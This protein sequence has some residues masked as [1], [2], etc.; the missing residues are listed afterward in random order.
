MTQ[1]KTHPVRSDTIILWGDDENRED[2]LIKGR[3]CEGSLIGFDKRQIWTVYPYKRYSS[4]TEYWGACERK[5][6][7]IRLGP[8]DFKKIFGEDIV[9][10]AE[11]NET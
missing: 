9:E 8:K 11:R 7:Y 6:L 5:G 1:I 10:K 4:D 3:N 2:K